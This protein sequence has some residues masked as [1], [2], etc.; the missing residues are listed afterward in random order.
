MDTA[1]LEDK[2]HRLKVLGDEAKT[3]VE[4]PVTNIRYE[5]SGLQAL[6]DGLTLARAYSER[7]SAIEAE[8]MLIQTSIRLYIQNLQEQHQDVYDEIVNANKTQ[9]DRLSW[10]ERAS[11]YRTK[12][13]DTLIPY[14]KAQKCQVYTEGVVQA[15]GILAR[16]AYRTRGDL[17]ALTEIMRIG[18]RLGEIDAIK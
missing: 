10:D 12:S 1:E 5:T 17:S 11:I 4:V 16:Q 9:Y 14:R 6:F 15:I 18:N 7:M 8:V 13:L 3:L 2:I